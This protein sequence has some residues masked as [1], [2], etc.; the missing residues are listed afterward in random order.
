MGPTDSPRGPQDAI[1]PPTG[2]RAAPWRP[3]PPSPRAA[4]AAARRERA[5]LAC[6]G[7]FKGG[8]SED[9]KLQHCEFLL[10]SDT[11][12][13]DACL[14]KRGVSSV[15]QRLCSHQN[16]R[17]HTRTIR[18]HHPTCADSLGSQGSACWHSCCAAQHRMSGMP[19]GWSAPVVALEP[20][21]RLLPAGRAQ[22]TQATQ[23]L[24]S[25]AAIIISSTGALGSAVQRTGAAVAV[26]R[27][28]AYLPGLMAARWW[29]RSVQR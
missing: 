15:S 7:K 5:L 8:V 22:S 2:A 20:W 14:S 6:L 27:A 21:Q 13:V 12:V 17:L 23:K 9:C 3:A 29:V 18:T 19:S 10:C 16:E 4:P 1:P 11:T 24:G 28:R 26:E 25:A